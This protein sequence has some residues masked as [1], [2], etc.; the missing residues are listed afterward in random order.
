MV[1]SSAV[2]LFFFLPSVF[3][4]YYLF[5]NDHVRNGILIVSSLIFYAF[6]E[7]VI[8][9]LM[10]FSIICNY[11]FG[12][13]MDKNKMLRRIVLILSVV[14]NIGILI[15]FKYS[16][17]IC[18][19][20]NTTGFVKVPVPH[21]RLPIGISFFTFQALSYVIDAYRGDIK[22]QKNILKLTLYI[23][24]FPQL[25]AGPIVK[26][27]DIESQLSHRE[28]SLTDI[29]QGIR[30]FICG[31]SKKIIIAD[32]LSRVAD[33]AFSL[34]D[35][36]LST[37][38]AWSGAVCYTLQIYFD[39]SGYSDMAIGMG[40]MFGFTFMENF[41][42]P[43]ISTSI[44]EFWRRWHISVS[45]WF[46]EYL[47]FP[48]GGN[49]K[50]KKR[51]VLNKWIVF[52]FTGLWHGAAMTFVIWGFLNGL[53]IMLESYNIVPVKKMQKNILLRALCHIYTM[54]VVVVCFVVFRSSSLGQSIDFI[55]SMFF[56]NKISPE[57]S[58]NNLSMLMTYATPLM[59][60][61]LCVSVVL[62]TPIKRVIEKR[63]ILSEKKSA[64]VY[65]GLSY[66]AAGILYTVCILYLSSGT[67]SPF[68]YLNF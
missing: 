45:T 29:S 15:V 17:F 49:R 26:Y 2:F 36:Q 56:I 57:Q 64:S 28:A 12:R 50:G 51:T 40:K 65:N 18:E 55:K 21:I 42:Y 35:G 48:L 9:F 37:L 24:C 66:A 3:G 10:I 54:I 30:R 34:P 53:F 16:G 31:L 4:I 67:Y 58:L 13:F 5:R 1:F 41:N 61:I 44:T 52:L 8:V 14:F 27:K 19:L 62:S 60:T 25:I 6:G 22:I 32:T 68:I 39:F 47:Y 43:Y 59:I 7:P 20:I 46:K 63:T 23:V 33:A 11:I 38:F